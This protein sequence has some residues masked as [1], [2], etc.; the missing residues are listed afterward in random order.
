MGLKLTKIHRGSSFNEE[1]WVKPYIDLNTQLR[2]K[3]TKDFEKDFFKL[4]SNSV[5]GKAMENIRNRIDVRLRTSEKS[6]EKLVRKPNY[7]RT[8]I[9]SEDLIAIQV[10]KTELVFNKPVYLGMA[11]LD[12]S[13]T[14][15][16][17]FQYNYIKVKYG[18]D[19]KLLMTDTDSLMYEVKTEDVYKDIREDVQERFDTSNFPQNHSSGILRMN[20]K[21]P[22]KFKDEC[23]GEIISEFCGLRA[24]LYA[25]KKD[26]EEEKRCKWVKKPVVSKS[27]HVEYYKRCLFT[28]K[29]EHQKM[30]VI[31]SREHEQFTESVNKIALCQ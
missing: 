3:A 15:M 26:G 1:A 20:K 17:Y 2:T 23:G 13:K 11:I 19:C 4:M 14:H 6:A 28:G 9:F 29:E 8:T 21:V 16:N 5:F 12:I 27:I 18:E 25:F 31:R 22:G 10:E 30:N 24:K 7:E